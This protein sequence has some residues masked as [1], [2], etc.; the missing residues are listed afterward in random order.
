VEFRTIPEATGS[1]AFCT[2]TRG[3][4]CTTTHASKY[5]KPRVGKGVNGVFMYL[6]GSEVHGIPLRQVSDGPSKTY[7]I[8]EV[9][10]GHKKETR[11]RWTAAGRYV[12]SLRSTENPMN[13]PVGLGGFEFD[14]N[15]YK[16]TGCFSSK[17]P[18]GA[19]F[20]FGDGHVEFVN[21]DIAIDVYQAASTRAAG[22]DAGS[23]GVATPTPGCL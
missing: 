21:E 15:G 22:D 8:G 6:Q 9:A 1:Y 12:D 11:N 20:G 7:F 5:R 23:T 14:S 16:T 18:G 19:I 17:H 4:S 13:T 10:E 3:P 2:G